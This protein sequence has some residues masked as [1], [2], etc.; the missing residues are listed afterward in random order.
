MPAGGWLLNDISDIPDKLLRNEGTH[1]CG[2]LGL[3][4]VQ[5]RQQNQ[6]QQT[7]TGKLGQRVE[8][9]RSF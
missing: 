1:A 4:F 3:D 6:H 8:E 7:E 5:H 2:N 9:T